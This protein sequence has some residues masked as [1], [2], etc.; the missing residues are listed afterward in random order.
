MSTSDENGTSGKVHTLP[1]KHAPHETTSA[2]HAHGHAE[3]PPT[4]GHPSGSGD[5]VPHVLPLSVYIATWVTLLVLT[6]ITVGASYVDFGSV[7]ILI[8]LGIA[9]IKAT[10]VAMMF[11]HLRWD[12]KFHAIIFSFSLIFLA[13]FIA[14]TMYDTETRGRTDKTQADRSAN[15]KAPFKG[16]VI[17]G[18]QEIKL[19]EQYGLSPGKPLPPP[20]VAPPN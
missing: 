14:F 16:G 20:P 3:R 15:V 1:L 19:K 6:A 8:A 13:I 5:H 11:M 7:N 10:V 18:K 4:H 12:H 17:D 9:T 2:D